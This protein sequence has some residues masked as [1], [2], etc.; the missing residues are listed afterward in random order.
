MNNLQKLAIWDAIAAL[1]ATAMG[2]P[3]AQEI[4]MLKQKLRAL[5]SAKGGCNHN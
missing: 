2:V 5:E 1:E 3:I 4:W